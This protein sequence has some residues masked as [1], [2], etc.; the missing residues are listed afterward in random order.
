MAV[1]TVLL[2]L[3]GLAAVVALMVRASGVRERRDLGVWRPVAAGAALLW[4]GD[5][6]A[7][8]GGGPGPLG[9]P[10]ASATATAGILLVA[11]GQLALMRQHLDT[12]HLRGWLDLLGGAP[13]ALAVLAAVA[14]HPL[15][16]ATGASGAEA[17]AAL[18]RTSTAGHAAV[19]TVV[20]VLLA[21]SVRERRSA[22]VLAA[23]LALLPVEVAGLVLG[24]TARPGGAATATA[25]LVPVA[26][27]AAV[28]VLLALA[29]RNP[30]AALA[31]RPREG[32]AAVV[33]GPLVFLVVAAA[34]LGADHVA[35]VPTVAVVCALGVIALQVVSV[36]VVYAGLTDLFASRDQSL[37]DDLT[38]LG[39]R[40][41][42]LA[43]LDRTEQRAGT[44]GHL[45][46]PVAL[47]LVD[48]DRFKVVN[49][50]LGHDAGDE[51]LRQV[52]RRLRAASREG[53]LLTRQGGD[54]FAVVLT[55]ATAQEA[56]RR[57]RDVVLA[58]EAPFV[59]GGARVGVDASVGVAA[60]PEHAED[61]EHLL[62]AA[63]AAMY[64]AKGLG[65]GVVVYDASVDRA[66]RDV[67]ALT[68]DL[69]AAVAADALTTVFQPQVGADGTLAGVE[70]LVR[71]EHPVRG[72]LE[73][74]A[75]LPLAE[76]HGL[77]P[78]LTEQVLARALAV[79]ADLAVAV[80]AA[81]GAE[82]VRV[83][84]N[85][86]ATSLR[87]DS[88][89]AAVT[90]LLARTTVPAGSLV[91]E[92]TETQL[93]DDPATAHGVVQA[94]VALGVGISIDDY[95]TGYSSLA[96]LV[97]LPASELKLDRSLVAGAATDGRLAAIVS[98]TVTLAH[99]LGMRLVAEGVE[100]RETLD[101]VLGLGVDVTQGFWH[102][103]PLSAQDLLAWVGRRPAA[104]GPG[105]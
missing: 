42:L 39:N 33:L 38:G 19:F 32:T 104:A 94:L 15:Q 58:V 30:C 5:V 100:D 62:R 98:S 48:L 55:G 25:V 40:R 41:A 56:A 71:W 97:D 13:L 82:P 23:V 96:H 85:A 37:T 50:T 89:V 9:H 35:D 18:A 27:H 12:H 65:G 60:W 91:V 31:E 57:A 52:A 76:R 77:M 101:V 83:S 47:A 24:W 86:S 26:G 68:A 63:D 21:R 90:A 84:V 73:P 75:F 34:I 43:H 99:D 3:L 4:L 92:I 87:D 17:V 79:A 59:I 103:G 20:S 95:G 64:R 44:G 51:L 6:P 45:A 80:G 29:G 22:L 16:R 93:V 1:L 53:D 69:R 7:V 67:E 88:L 74:E 102:A 72:A 8:L 14:L 36:L 78:T 61:A 70:A 105:G 2:A 81:P 46:E 54:E 49:D 10:A 11:V 66:R 28:L